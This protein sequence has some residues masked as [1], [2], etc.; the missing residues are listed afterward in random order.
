MGWTGVSEQDRVGAAEIVPPIAA[1]DVVVWISVG[2]ATS[3]MALC[4][5]PFLLICLC[6]VF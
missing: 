5:A 2:N 3:F 6:D 4:V 1:S